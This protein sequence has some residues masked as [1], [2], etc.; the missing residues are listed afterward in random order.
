MWYS[1]SLSMITSWFYFTTL[2]F[3]RLFLFINFT[4]PFIFWILTEIN[5]LLFVCLLLMLGGIRFKKEIND[6]ILF[7]FIVQ[8]LSSIFILRNFFFCGD[9]FIFNYGNIFLLAILIKLG[10]FPFFYWVFKLARF[11]NSCSLPLLLGF[12]KI[13]FF[14]VLFSMENSI[15]MVLISMSLLSGSLMIIWSNTFVNILVCSSISYRF[16][17]FYLYGIRA[18]LFIFFFSIYSL[19]LYLMYHSYLENTE[20]R[21]S[22]WF[23]IFL[24][25]FFLGLTPLSLFFFKI[26]VVQFVFT[27][28]GISEILRFWVLSFLG[29]FGYMKFSFKSFFSSVTVYSNIFKS[30]FLKALF[31][32]ARIIFFLFFLSF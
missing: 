6:L 25:M 8:S 7:Y 19:L 16:W 3:A 22:K 11:I 23:V 17:T 5:L 18:Y 20:S 21:A 24:Y 32:F 13:P 31:Y 2:Y 10:I 26:L 4:S 12:Q 29:L 28:M 15:L 30:I 14:M 1:P 9:F 27:R